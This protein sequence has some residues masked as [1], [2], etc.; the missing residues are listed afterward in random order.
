MLPFGAHQFFEVF[1]RYNS[2]VW[3][4][5]IAL[6][7]AALVAVILA[8]RPPRGIRSSDRCHPGGGAAVQLGVWE[9]LGLAAQPFVDRII[10]S[11]LAFLHEDHGADRRDRLGRGGEPENGISPH[12]RLAVEGHAADRLHVLSPA[13]VDECHEPGDL[14]T[15]DVTL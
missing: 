14:A 6:E 15:V 8:L 12:R 1:A 10:E 2:V 9:D 13:V 7:L 5:P 4:A 11:D 3:P